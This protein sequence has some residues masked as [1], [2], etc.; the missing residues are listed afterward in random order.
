MTRPF[1]HQT[2]IAA[3]LAVSLLVSA[4][5]AQGADGAAAAIVQSQPAKRVV[6]TFVVASVLNEWTLSFSGILAAREEVA[7]GAPLQDQRISS[8][9]VEVGDRVEAGQVLV[10]LETAMRDNQLRESEGRVARANAALAQQQAKA[11]QAQAALQRAGPLRQSGIIS[12]QAL[13]DR[14]STAAIERQGVA[15][16]QAEVNQ[17]EAQ[18]A[19][20]RRLLERAVIV[21]PVAGIVSERHANAGALTGSEPL[22]RLIRGGEV[23]LAADIPERELSQLA[24]GQPA[25][26]R[27]PGSDDVIRGKVR[28]ITPK[29]DRDTRLGGAR[30]TLETDAALFPGAFGRA[31]VVV[32]KREAI[33]I[34]D[35]ALLY[36]GG[37]N[38]AAVFVVE[39]GRV[40]RRAVETGLRD[41]GRLE[42]RAG[43][44]AGDIVVA[45]AGA[46][47]REG[48][49]VATADVGAITGSTRP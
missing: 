26:V 44:K 29:I 14:A 7:V 1:S 3:A 45:K 30:V 36:G 2:T 8:V 10:R 49:E 34:A 37:A 20:S 38:K 23:E 9:G 15:L 24:A 40:V 33:V 48:D 35:S 18:L 46:T 16:A 19:E 47:L 43:L 5:A 32:A 41:N 28:M 39:Q 31:E 17:A 11:A 6:S 42:I 25:E 13:A 27:L 22:I 4:G 12:S 21:A